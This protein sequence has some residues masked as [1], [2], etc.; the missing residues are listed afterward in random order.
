MEKSEFNTYKEGLDLGF[1]RD[2]CL[3]YGT[4]RK[5]MRGE[6]LEETGEPARCPQIIEQ[7]SLQDI[8][9]FLG[10]TATYLSRIRKEIAEKTE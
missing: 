7:L 6:T 3:E 1:L 9:S 8:A 10:I 4:V 5:M 2:Y